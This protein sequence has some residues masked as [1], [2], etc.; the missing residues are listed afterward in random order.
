MFCLVLE[1]VTQKI[2]HSSGTE[3]KYSLLDKVQNITE[4]LRS[5]FQKLN[6]TIHFTTIAP[7]CIQNYADFQKLRGNLVNS[8][9]SS[10]EMDI[11]RKRYYTHQEICHFNSLYMV[12]AL[13]V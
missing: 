6:C 2:N 9:I 7:V 4:I 11:I 12:P 8:M 3:I 13:F 5:T 10:I 1:F